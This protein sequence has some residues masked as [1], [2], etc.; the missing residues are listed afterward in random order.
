M[1]DWLSIIESRV[2]VTPDLKK[3]FEELLKDAKRYRWVRDVNNWPTSFDS[4]GEAGQFTEESYDEFIDKLM[5]GDYSEEDY[6]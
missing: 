6:E 2:K 4:Y 3:P 1:I 5:C